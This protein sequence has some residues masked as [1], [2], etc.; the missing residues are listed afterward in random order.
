[1]KVKSMARKNRKNMT[2]KA[3]IKRALKEHLF[4]FGV[5]AVLA[6]YCVTGTLEKQDEIDQQKINC[7]SAAYIHD[8]PDKCN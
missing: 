5:V 1:M 2:V 7:A 4:L 3:E 6:A 8:N